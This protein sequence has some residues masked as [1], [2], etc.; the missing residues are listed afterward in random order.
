MAAVSN[1]RSN[2]GGAKANKV[3]PKI[4]FLKKKKG[5]NNILKEHHRFPFLMKLLLLRCIHEI[6]AAQSCGCLQ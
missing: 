5:G 4:V 1:A 6:S 2:Y 3:N